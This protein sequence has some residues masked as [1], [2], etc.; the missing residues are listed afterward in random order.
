MDVSVVIINWNTKDLVCNCVRSVYKA[1]G[2]I[3][4]EIIVVDNG[5]N[6]GSVEAIKSGF[7]DVKIISNEQNKGYAAAVNQGVRISQGKYIL[8]LNSD[9]VLYERAIEQTFNYAQQHPK[10]AIIGCRVMVDAETVQMTCFKFPDLTNFALRATGLSWLFPKNRFFG[11]ESMS[12]WN[13]DTEQK[14]DV[15]SGMFMFV[16]REAVDNVGLMDEDYF[17]YSEDVDWCYRFSKAGWENIFWPGAQ[18]LHFHG[19]GQSSRAVRMI[20]FVQQQKSTL[21]FFSKHRGMIACLFARLLMSVLFGN[22]A[23]G[24]AV[25][26]LLKKRT[27]PSYESIIANRNMSW[28]AFKYCLLGLEPKEKWQQTTMAGRNR[29]I[30]NTIE[31]L[32][33]GTYFIISS[34]VRR[35]PVVLTIYYHSVPDS[36]LA[37]FEK[38]IEFL[39]GH[40]RVV[41]PSQIKSTPAETNRTVIAITFDDG[42]ISVFRNALP[43]LKK[44]GLPSA[45][46]VPSGYISKKSGW[47]MYGEGDEENVMTGEQIKAASLMDCEILSHTVTHSML[48]SLSSETLREEFVRSRQDL[49]R[50]LGRD[51]NIVCYPY[52]AYNSRVCDA[53]KDAGYRLG[54]TTEPN[55]I[56]EKMDDYEI[57]RFAVSAG[58]GLLKFKLKV[59][60]AYVVSNYLRFAKRKLLSVIN[61]RR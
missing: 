53:A 26:A 58:D 46:F 45:I 49:E 9:I 60:G 51:I 10:A 59:S 15:V 24:W 37:Q 12:W 14:V 21:L 36:Q 25:I 61:W 8:V 34:V 55:I 47:Q 20:S 39:A 41:A 43:V 4:F 5:S 18:A 3:S 42:F 17:F 7:A 33:A 30:V 19:G 40:C 11:R 44:H 22:R 57:G 35:K 48:T 56:N 54:F 6:D 38:Q 28:C 29:F 13:R 2:K 50:I 32:C 31:F 52:G 16:R 1:V 23:I 27:D